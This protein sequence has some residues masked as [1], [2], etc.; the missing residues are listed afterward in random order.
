VA[1]VDRDEHRGFELL[2]RERASKN[3]RMGNTLVSWEVPKLPRCRGGGYDGK[4]RTYYP[5]VEHD[6]PRF[7]SRPDAK[8][9]I[10][11]FLADGGDAAVVPFAEDEMRNIPVRWADSL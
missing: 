6:A 9:A 7:N 11:D 5:I 1:R 10:D 4:P 2:R 8:R 3:R